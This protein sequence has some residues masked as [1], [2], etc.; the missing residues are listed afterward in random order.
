MVMMPPE[1]V[2]IRA[3]STVLVKASSLVN[4]DLAGI[5]GHGL[6]SFEEKA[7]LAAVVGSLPELS[8]GVESG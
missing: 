5:S 3:S 1:D 2:L 8:D 6:V 7:G 4:L